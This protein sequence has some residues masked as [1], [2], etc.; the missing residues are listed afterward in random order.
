MYAKTL[1]K[2]ANIV[3]GDTDALRAV[4]KNRSQ[5]KASIILPENL[6]N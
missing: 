1:E 3:L 2:S 6:I 4:I 5:C